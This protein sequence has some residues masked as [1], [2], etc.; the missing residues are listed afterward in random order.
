MC[1]G[2]FSL[3]RLIISI[4]LRWSNHKWTAVMDSCLH[5][6]FSCVWNAS[7]VTTSD[8]VY[9]VTGWPNMSKAPL[10]HCK[11]RPKSSQPQTKQSVYTYLPDVIPFPVITNE[12]LRCADWLIKAIF[13]LSSNC[14]ALYAVIAH[15]IMFQV[16]S[17]VKNK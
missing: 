17:T 8:C 2:L 15:L 13:I 6:E 1:L 11:T 7:P 5:Q 4:C 12:I 9:L 3:F 10:H 16:I 14:V